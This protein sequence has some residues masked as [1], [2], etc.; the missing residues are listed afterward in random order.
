[1]PCG[2]RRVYPYTS[3]EF[4]IRFQSHFESRVLFNGTH[5]ITYHKEDSQ[6]ETIDIIPL[7]PKALTFQVTF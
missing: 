2:G 5:F 7:L 1:M 3:S 4:L 6:T